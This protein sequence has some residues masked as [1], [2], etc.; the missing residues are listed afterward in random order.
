MCEYV[1]VSVCVYV[2]MVEGL[3]ECTDCVCECVCIP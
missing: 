2:L 3:A 1:F